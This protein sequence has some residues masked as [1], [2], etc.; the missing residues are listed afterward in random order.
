MKY[1]IL[2]R[3]TI[4]LLI[5]VSFSGLSYSQTTKTVTASCGKCGRSVPSTSSVGGTCPH[6]GVRWGR[7]N[8]STTTS[9]TFDKT[10]TQIKLP[11]FELD[12]NT[13]RDTKS[14][15]YKSNLM[16]DLDLS[17]DLSKVSK[18]QLNNKIDIPNEKIPTYNPPTYNQNESSTIIRNCKLMSSPNRNSEILGLITKNSSIIINKRKGDWLKITYVGNLEGKIDVY[19]GWIYSSNAVE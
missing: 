7:E 3:L 15:G 19:V 18:I 2:L 6:C 10:N 13:G 17:L 8:K 9:S 1:L 16:E 11:T 14:S 4:T 12:Y 5:G